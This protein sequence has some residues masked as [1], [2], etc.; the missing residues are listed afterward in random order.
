MIAALTNRSAGILHQL[1]P[2]RQPP[3][4][5]DDL[6]RPSTAEQAYRMLSSDFSVADFNRIVSVNAGRS[7][8][9]GYTEY[10][11][12]SANRQSIP[13]RQ[14]PPTS[15]MADR[16]APLIAIPG[17]IPRKYLKWG[18]KTFIKPRSFASPR[19]CGVIPLPVARKSPSFLRMKPT[20]RQCLT[21]DSTFSRKS[22]LVRK[23]PIVCF[24]AV[25]NKLSRE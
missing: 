23:E 25:V 5:A 16:V 15:S 11:A 8:C 6:E 4:Q 2:Y 20:A 17:A 18:G 10:S 1:P 12:G 14:N 21:E 22:S 3:S 24:H 9:A 19:A 13:G 7:S